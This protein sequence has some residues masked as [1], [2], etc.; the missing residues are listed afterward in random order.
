MLARDNATVAPGKWP[1]PYSD[2]FKVCYT[3]ATYAPVAKQCC[4]SLKAESTV[5]EGNVVNCLIQ[6]N[7]TAD[8]YKNWSACVTE[9][10]NNSNLK[11]LGVNCQKAGGIPL[12]VGLGG[13]ALIVAT[14]AL[15]IITL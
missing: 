2:D 10:A 7:S 4:D 8:L 5:A 6:D 12:R 3:N 13:V 15:S 11:A 14:V 9:H 1:S